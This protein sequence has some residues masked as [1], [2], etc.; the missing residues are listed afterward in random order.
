M[1][2]KDRCWVKVVLHGIVSLI[3]TPMSFNL[4]RYGLRPHARENQKIWN[5]GV[6]QFLKT[7]FTE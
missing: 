4:G 2:K 1:G 7:L 6:I 5:H 3:D